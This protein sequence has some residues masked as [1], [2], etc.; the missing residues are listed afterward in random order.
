MTSKQG[1]R[2]SAIT[3]ALY[4]FTEVQYYDGNVPLEWWSKQCFVIPVMQ[5]PLKRVYNVV[6]SESGSER[7]FK[8]HARWRNS[9]EFSFIAAHVAGSKRS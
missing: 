8:R 7:N 3:S 5:K 1:V 2:T 6:P 4:N 9:S